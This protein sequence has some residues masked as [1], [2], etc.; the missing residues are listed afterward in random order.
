[1]CGGGPTTTTSGTSTVEIPGY[2]KRAG[3]SNLRAAANYA[4]TWGKDAGYEPQ[5]YQG[6]AGN[7]NW[8]EGMMPYQQALIANLYQGGG[9]GE[10]ADA[11]RNAYAQTAPVYGQYLGEGFLD[12]M[13]NPYLQPS[14][15]AARS[16]AFNDVADRFH[17]AGRSFS[18]AEAG[19]FG[20]AATKAAL[21]ML[22][23]Q[24][25]QNA[26]LQQGAAQ[27]LLGAAQG[28]SAG[29]DAAQKGILTAQMAAPQQIANLNI[30]ENMLLGITDRQ[31][32][33]AQD[34]LNMRI[35]ALSGTP[36]GSTTTTKGTSSMQTDPFQTLLGGGLGLLG[37]LM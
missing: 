22:M 2:I 20:D 6:I 31:R 28:T 23:G 12:P 17:K 35:A 26:G 21:P 29:L 32:Q 11:I 1:M 30:P 18:G 24:Y 14:I 7:A 3:K 5:A 16:G 10:G 19:A 37:L 36:Y 25:N 13:S 27:G 4:N 15:E 33:A 8:A 34:A 9:M